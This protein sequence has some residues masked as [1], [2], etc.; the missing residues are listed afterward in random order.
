ML[1]LATNVKVVKNKLGLLELEKSLGNISLKP[2]RLC[3]IQERAF[4]FIKSSMKKEV[5]LLSKR[6]LG[7]N[8]VRRIVWKST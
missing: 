1:N 4:I 5:Q 2:A 6:S 7:E 3:D 8:L